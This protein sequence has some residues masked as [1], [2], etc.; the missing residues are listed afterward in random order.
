MWKKNFLWLF[1]KH[2][3]SILVFSM[4]HLYLFKGTTTSI[5]NQTMFF[6]LFRLLVFFFV[7]WNAYVSGSILAMKCTSSSFHSITHSTHTHTHSHM[8]RWN[9]VKWKKNAG[10]ICF[11]ISYY[12]LNSLFYV[13]LCTYMFFFCRIHKFMYIDRYT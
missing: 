12:Y 9:Q 5:Y 7:L 8:K 1:N 13:S 11:C 3:N 10:N 4:K 6:V 2:K